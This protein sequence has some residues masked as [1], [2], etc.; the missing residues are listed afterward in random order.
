MGLFQ[1]KPLVGTSVPLY[2]LG[3][4]KTLL[5][6]GLGNIGKQYQLTRHNVGFN[7]LNA[8]AET[9]EFGPW[10]VKKDLKCQLT[11]KV[12]G[13]VQVLLV[14]PTT[15]MNISGEAVQAVA[16]FYKIDFNQIAAVQ[17]EL[18]IPFGQ[19]RMRVGG[20]A[21]GHNGI[22]SLIQHIGDE[23]GRI[24]IGIQQDSAAP[25][26]EETKP[27][28]NTSDFVLDKFTKTEQAL[29]PNLYREVN[30]ILTEYVYRGELQPE[31]RSFI[32]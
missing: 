31:T 16:H 22:K 9:H 6:V 21:A 15:M 18:D 29:L 26:P 24:R 11:S 2:T 8:F 32:V 19:I 10:V 25:T 30:S 14:K 23:F 3:L 20:G 13:D 27:K 5:I 1:K 7:C 12:L 4:N 28:Q 17:D